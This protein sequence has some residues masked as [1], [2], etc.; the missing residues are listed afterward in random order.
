MSKAFAKSRNMHS[1]GLL[2]SKVLYNS[3]VNEQIASCVLLP[4]LNPNCLSDIKLYLSK[5][6]TILTL[7]TFS[8]IF[9]KFVISDIGL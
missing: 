6:L 4:S 1:D 2:R 8:T 3:V 9:A 7:I 5:N